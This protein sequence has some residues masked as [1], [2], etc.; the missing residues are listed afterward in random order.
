MANLLGLAIR[1][2]D[3]VI[4]AES[5]PKLPF[6]F[7]LSHALRLAPATLKTHPQEKE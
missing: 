3:F 5:G 4:A 2:S 6:A 1:H 7:P